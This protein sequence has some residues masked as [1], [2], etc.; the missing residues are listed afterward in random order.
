M[1]ACLAKVP[2][3]NISI[4]HVGRG[5]GYVMFNRGCNYIAFTCVLCCG[6]GRYW[7]Y[8]CSYKESK[9]H[10]RLICID[11]VCRQNVKWDYFLQRRRTKQFLFCQ[12]LKH[13]IMDLISKVLDTIF[14]SPLK[15]MGGKVY[16]YDRRI[17]R[18]PE[19]LFRFYLFN[20]YIFVH[21]KIQ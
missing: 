9:C 2:A 17:M 8:I 20:K 6:L 11:D 12:I 3:M 10:S 5:G 15:R 7:R 4:S 1:F 19:K 16:A 18:K 13:Y 21:R 14:E